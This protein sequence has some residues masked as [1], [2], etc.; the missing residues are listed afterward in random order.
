MPR[1][2]CHPASPERAPR[3]EPAA[4]GG[5]PACRTVRFERHLLALPAAAAWFLLLLTLAS[6]VSAHYQKQP[7]I[8]SPLPAGSTL[9]VGFLN[10]HNEGSDENL[11]DGPPMQL[12]VRLRALA[13]PGVYIDL[14]GWNDRASVRN[15]I[16][17]ATLRDSAG[18]CTKDGCREVLLILYGQARGGEAVHK[19]AREL[20]RL[21]LPVALTLQVDNVGPPQE[22][23]PP[24]VARAA[25]LAGDWQPYHPTR[26]R[27]EDPARTRI[28]ANLRYTYDGRW[29]DL[30]ANNG[31][32]LSSHAPRPITETA[33]PVWNRVEDY[34][35]EELRLAGIPGAPAPPHPVTPPI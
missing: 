24:N 19:L 9:I 35:L 4:A 5:G 18:R 22:T 16:K 6:A 11:A 12:A 28:L 23:V 30:A 2:S 21:G 13:L 33:P 27:A 10:G 26:I 31:R 14:V 1:P 8:P 3:R 29:V 20:G 17:S 25:S 7:P 34:I 32:A 15:W